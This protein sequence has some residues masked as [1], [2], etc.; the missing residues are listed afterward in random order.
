MSTDSSDAALVTATLAGH[1]SAFET[2]VRRYRRVALLRARAITEDADAAEDVVQDAFIRV[3]DHLPL[4]RDR[5]QFGPWLMTAVRHHAL[6]A[7]RARHRRRLVPLDDSIP[8]AGGG[9]VDASIEAEEARSR[10]A[11]ALAQLSTRQREIFLLAEV[12]EL[13]HEEIARLV[14]TTVLSSR[15]YLADARARLRSLLSVEED[16]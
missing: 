9:A 6:N 13:S 11:T 16:R 4:L 14:G 15:R 1:A 2:L 10:I 5:G 3:H 7:T 12:E 8:L